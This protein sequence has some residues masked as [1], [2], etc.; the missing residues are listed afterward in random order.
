MFKNFMKIN[1]LA[2]ALIMAAG[3]IISAFAG[4]MI[5]LGDGG[6]ISLKPGGTKVVA[7]NFQNDNEFGALQFDMEFTSDKVSIVEGS[8]VVNDE[9][10]SR[11]LFMSTLYHM[12]NGKWR[13]SVLSKPTA[14]NFIS[15]HEGVL[16]YFTIKA[17]D[18]FTKDD[19]A[20][21]YFSTSSGGDG[22]SSFVINTPNYQAIT[23]LVGSFSLGETAFSIK[24]GGTHKVD[25]MLNNDVQFNGL[26][27]DIAL[28]EGLTIEKNDKGT[29]KFEYSDRL[30]NNFMISSALQKDGKVRVMLSSLPVDEIKGKE[31]TLFSFN[32]VADKNF[33]SDENSVISFSN[34]I[35][36][37]DLGV[38]EY[39]LD[40]EKAVAKVTS[41]KGDND[42]AYVR[43]VEEVATLQKTLDDAKAKV[44]EECKDVAENYVEAVEAI[45][46]QI[47]AIKA[48]LNLKNENC[49]LTAESVLDAEAVKAVKEAVEKYVADAQ[50]AQADVV[51]KAANEAAYKRLSEELAAVQ[52]RFDEVKGIIDEKYSNVAGQFVG[53]E[54]TI[55]LEINRVSKE[56]KAQYENIEL[57]EE[58]QLDVQVLKDTIEQ[59]LD[60]AK[61]ASET[62]GINGI[63]N[64]AD[65]AECIGV[66][67]LD[68]TEVNA[69]V[70]GQ[71]YVVRYA[72][73][74]T[75]KVFIR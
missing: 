26:Q 22:V 51:K 44:A 74:K 54:M 9:R 43:L 27:T 58:S 37:A 53:V 8:L 50:A 12:E 75:M 18:D 64:G 38:V 33:V 15:G 28:P 3:S 19:G 45:Q 59:L 68:G 35:A 13:L 40:T 63:L 66:Y 16:A 71:T 32:V 65:G 4:N 61:K 7:V 73:G 5:T 30:S 21:V 47:D 14:I 70:K 62:A 24:P 57:T 39:S 29:Y 69:P 25:V 60:D 52:A 41:L 34:T 11:E 49:D 55:Q 56:L 17:A 67:T 42:A 2:L 72:D 23:P 6:T 31:G 20:K 1:K 48:D 10:A 36:T 46:K